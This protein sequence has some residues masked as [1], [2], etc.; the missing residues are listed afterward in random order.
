MVVLVIIGIASAALG[1]ASRPDPA[2][3]LREDARRLALQLPLAQAEAR[4]RNT[5]IRWQADRQGYRLV[6]V[7]SGE[8]LRDTPLLRPAE[9]RAGSLDIQVQPRRAVQLEAEW[10]VPATQI[11]LSDGEHSVVVERETDGHVRVR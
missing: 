6:V 7:G 4:L 1:L 5:P 10:I 2:R 11:R 8:V 9:W 3:L